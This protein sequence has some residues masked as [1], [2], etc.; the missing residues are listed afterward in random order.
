[1]TGILECQA[2]VERWC[3][4]NGKTGDVRE[5]VRVKGGGWV[6]YFCWH[7]SPL[8]DSCELLVDWRATFTVVFF[9]DLC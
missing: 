9:V 5:G 2:A 4:P 7:V 3:L 8:L 6:G 1:M